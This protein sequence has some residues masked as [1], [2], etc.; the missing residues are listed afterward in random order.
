MWSCE[1][2]APLANRLGLRRNILSAFQLSPEV[3]SGPLLLLSPIEV[4]RNEILLTLLEKVSFQI[5]QSVCSPYIC[6]QLLTEFGSPTIGWALNWE[7]DG[8]EFHQIGSIITVNDESVVMRV[9]D[10]LI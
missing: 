4:D 10:G 8:W 5:V 1:A 9:D 7:F 2:S 3:D 6:A